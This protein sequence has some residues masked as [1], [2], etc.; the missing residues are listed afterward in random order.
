MSWRP[1][2]GAL[3]LCFFACDRGSNAPFPGVRFAERDPG[4]RVRI[5]YSY[6]HCF[7]GFRD[8]IHLT[9]R[10]DGGWSAVVGRNEL[11]EL[12]ETVFAETI[13]ES[14]GPERT[15]EWDLA[16][17]DLRRRSNPGEG[18]FM[19]S[20]SFRFDWDDDGEVEEE[21]VLNDQRLSGFQETLIP[22]RR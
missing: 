22:A 21:L 8:V 19:H 9:R 5:E 1:L 16:L 10:E 15:E 12:G 6:A 13:T 18:W 2:I 7:G 4:E 3:S 20:I 14:H 11:D 17:D